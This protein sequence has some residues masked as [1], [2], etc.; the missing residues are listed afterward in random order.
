MSSADL[1]NCSVQKLLLQ[2]LGGDVEVEQRHFN[3]DLGWV[4]GVRQL[5]GHVEAE[6]WVV[7]HHIVTNLDDFTAALQYEAG[8]V[9][10]VCCVGREWDLC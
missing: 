4:V 1:D 2:A 5:A 7:G 9:C 3:R 6:V 10:A 8:P